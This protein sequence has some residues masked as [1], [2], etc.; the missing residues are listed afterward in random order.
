MNAGF[1][2]LAHR[3]QMLH[4]IKAGLQIGPFGREPHSRKICNQHQCKD[5]IHRRAAERGG[6]CVHNEARQE[7]QT[8]S[9][10]DG[11]CDDEN[12]AQHKLDRVH[13]AGP[14]HAGFQRFQMHDVD[15]RDIGNRRRNN[16]G[17]DNLDIGNP[18]IFRHQERDRTHNRR[19]QHP[20]DRR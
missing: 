6:N 9:D 11:D 20:V 14:G 4:G 18:D 8:A 10:D 13:L 5:H 3:R 17:F 2:D 19:C 1:K 15:Q 12:R 16:R 7:Q